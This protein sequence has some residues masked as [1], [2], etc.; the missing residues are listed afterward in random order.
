M[1][2]NCNHLCQFQY[3]F[4]INLSIFSFSL[5]RGCPKAYHPTCIKRDEA[6]FRSKARWNCG[7]LFRL[8]IFCSWI[9]THRLCYLF[10]FPIRVIYYLDLLER[11][12]VALL[13]RLPRTKLSKRLLRIKL[14]KRLPRPFIHYHLKLSVVFIA[15]DNWGTL[16]YSVF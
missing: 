7:M 4:I 14:S 15:F 5:F 6:F 3:V 9:T 8:L 2:F 13:C 12:G 16:T 11:F 1:I 10:W